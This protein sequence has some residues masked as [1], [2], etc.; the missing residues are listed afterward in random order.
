MNY[1][2]TFSKLT[3]GSTLLYSPS[4]DFT[5]AETVV[6]KGIIQGFYYIITE[7]GPKTVLRSELQEK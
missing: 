4:E 1:P 5:T 7:N 2:R 6:L 3:E